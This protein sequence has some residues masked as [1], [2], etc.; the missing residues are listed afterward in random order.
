M[1]EEKIE[2]YGLREDPDLWE[3]LIEQEIQASGDDAAAKAVVDSMY[4]EMDRARAFQRYYESIDFGQISNLLRD[5]G[6]SRKD[7]LCEI[8]GGS[9]QL[10]WSL[11]KSGFEHVDLLEPNSRWITGTG[12]VQ[13]QLAEVGGAL[14]VCNDLQAWYRDEK[15][16]HTIVTRNCVHHFPNIPMVAAAIRQKVDKGGTWLLISRMVRSIRQPRCGAR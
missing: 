11:A 1:G 4:W 15:R 7:P 2:F 12:Y 10:A 13:S 14:R 9:G 16:Y 8:G 3:R 5:F 6:I